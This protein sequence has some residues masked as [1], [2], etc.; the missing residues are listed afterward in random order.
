MPSA[1][2]TRLRVIG[3]NAVLRY[4]KRPPTQEEIASELGANYLVEGS[5]R[6]SGQPACASPRN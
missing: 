1:A 3:R 6:R 2:S 4:K 5:V